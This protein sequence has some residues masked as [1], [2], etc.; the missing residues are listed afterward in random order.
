[1]RGTIDMSN[2][3][4]ARQAVRNVFRE[5]GGYNQAQVDVLVDTLENFFAVRQLD[6]EPAF[7][8]AMPDERRV[9]ASRR[10]PD[11]GRSPLA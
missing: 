7:A 9:Q 4:E 6:N 3:N 10:G 1:M 5:I 11:P 2:Y 8:P